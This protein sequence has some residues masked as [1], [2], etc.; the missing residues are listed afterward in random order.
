V[1]E[2]QRLKKVQEMAFQVMDDIHLNKEM[3]NEQ[4]LKNV[5]DNLSRAV[6]MFADPSR[7][8]SLDYIED[9]VSTAHSLIVKRKK[10]QSRLKN[11]Y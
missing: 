2:R 9:K 7:N 6:G 10:H 3:R 8:F 4:D 5:I 1:D 11:A